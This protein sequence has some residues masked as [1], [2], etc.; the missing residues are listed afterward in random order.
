MGKQLLT[1]QE[2]LASVAKGDPVYMRWDDYRG[3]FNWISGPENTQGTHRIEY[4]A[5]EAPM[6]RGRL[7]LV[8]TAQSAPTQTSDN[9]T[10]YLGIEGEVEFRI[11]SRTILVKPLDIIGIP[12]GTA[13]SYVNVGLANAQLCG[14]YAK[15]GGPATS[16][17]GSKTTLEPTHMKWEEYRRDFHWTLP[18]AE[19]W[20]YHRGSGPLI[21][22]EGLRGHT[23]RM[24]TGQTTPWHYAA[25]DM[26]FMGI[27]DEVEFKAGNKKMPLG[28][29]DWIIVPA[30]TP[31]TYTNYGLKEC[32]FF[33]IGGKL[34][35]G[36]KGT[37]FSED[38]G[39]PIRADAPTMTVEIDAH[40]DARVVSGS[41]IKP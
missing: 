41:P 17:A 33:S 37:Y 35:A 14:I 5:V 26:L 20:G 23:V 13:Y 16:G 40:G 9:D 36:K 1:L 3:A 10:A 22:M 19:H 8:P 39:W 2:S 18:L 15:S 24:P 29:R 12:A 21:M 7:L 27:S 6:A 30:G 11:G 4:P 25:R 32:L 34:P 38:P 28:P 31:Y